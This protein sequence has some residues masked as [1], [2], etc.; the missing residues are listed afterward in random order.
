M[1]VRLTNDEEL[2]T[3]A[4][5]IRTKGGTTGNLSYPS[6]FATAIGN[7]ASDCNATASQI[8]SGKT[9]WVGNAK[10]T[11]NIS[12]KA[13]ATYN[14][15]SSDQTISASQYLSGAQT[16]KAVT[17]SNISAANIKTGVNV[18]VGDANSAGR[19][20]NVTGTFTSDAN[21][22]AGDIL[23]GKT[24]YVNGT[25]IT[26]SLGSQAAATYNTSANDQTIAAGKYLSGAQTI[27]AVKTANIAAG[28]IKAGV[29]ITVGDANSAGRIASVAGT[30]TSDGTAAAGHIL[31]GKTAYVNGSKITGTIG[32]KAAATYNTSTGDQTISAGQYLSGNQ[33][34]KAVTTSNISAANIKL[35]V[36][37]KVGDANS[38]GRIANV[39]GTCVPL[40]MQS[41]LPPF[42][43]CANNT[44]I[45]WKWD[46]NG[47]ITTYGLTT[48]SHNY[49]YVA[50]KLSVVYYATGSSGTSTI[51]LSPGTRYELTG[52]YESGG[53][54]MVLV[55]VGNFYKIVSWTPIA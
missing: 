21:A 4:N 10:V 8:L 46:S 20:A 40:T 42:F 6:G 37:V 38:A 2:T 41:G 36:N 28:N 16:I 43:W 13:A 17:T 5:A 51:T 48:H 54:Q 3:V 22:A 19:I 29:T 55:G 34:I 35:G 45:L 50:T 33:T 44:C 1:A 30:F 7:I 24:A 27:K 18:K 25:K 39:T 47:Y 15:S 23:S 31:S 32:S 26:G 53:N 9:A 12:S 11:G 49:F 52:A 14:T